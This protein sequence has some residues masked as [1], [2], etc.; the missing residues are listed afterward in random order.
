MRWL[1]AVSCLQYGSARGYWFH[2][3]PSSAC[4]RSLSRWVCLL[5]IQ[6]GQSRTE[7]YLVLQLHEATV[8]ENYVYDEY[9]AYEVNEVYEDGAEITY[10]IVC[11]EMLRMSISCEDQSFA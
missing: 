4:C 11:I 10:E 3:V 5:A 6:V 9:D 8:G 2:G 1:G 7:A